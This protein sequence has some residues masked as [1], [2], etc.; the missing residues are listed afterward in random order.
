M[1][2]SPSAPTVTKKTRLALVL[3]SLYKM[4]NRLATIEAKLD[5]SVN[6][7]L[8]LQLVQLGE[9]EAWLEDSQKMKTDKRYIPHPE[10]QLIPSKESRS[11]GKATATY[12]QI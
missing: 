4:F 6:V 2:G 7:P 12:I 5:C 1:T 8:G 10:G 3:D 11:S 9:E